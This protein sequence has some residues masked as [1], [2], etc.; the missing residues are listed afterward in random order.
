MLNELKLQL[1]KN[2]SVMTEMSKNNPGRVFVQINEMAYSVSAKHGVS[3]QLHFPDSKKISDLNSFGTENMT[4]ILDPRRKKFLIPK[5]RIKE[6]AEEMFEQIE[7][8]D[9]FMYQGME[10]VKLFLQKGRIDILPGSINIWCQIG[11]DVRKFVDW[12]L[13]FCYRIGSI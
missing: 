2:K 3:L 8:K 9:A 10:G 7:S 12:L 11:D 5:D 1:E 6:K 13:I 4:I